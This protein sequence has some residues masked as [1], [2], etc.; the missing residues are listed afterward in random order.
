[1]ITDLTN[2]FQRN[3]DLLKDVCQARMEM[4]NFILGIS[5]DLTDEDY[6]FYQSELRHYK[7]YDV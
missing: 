7:F 4:C 3:P 2:C 6:A 5:P 1:M